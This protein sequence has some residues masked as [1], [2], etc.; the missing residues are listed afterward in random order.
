MDRN[1][2]QPD[3][4]EQITLYRQRVTEKKL[5][6][7]KLQREIAESVSIHLWSRM[8]ILHPL[9]PTPIIPLYARRVSPTS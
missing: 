7:K 3:C 5:E 9:M 4:H 1:A 2:K 6:L 8:R